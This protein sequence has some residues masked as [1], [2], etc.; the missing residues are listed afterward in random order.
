MTM[1]LRKVDNL[2]RMIRHHDSDWLTEFDI[3]GVMVREFAPRTPTERGLSVWWIHEDL[4]NLND[5]IAAIGLA[6]QRKLAPIQYLTFPEEIVSSCGLNLQQTN[7]ATCHVEAAGYHREILGLTALKT[8]TLTHEAC[9]R[10]GFQKEKLTEA[11]VLDRIVE[12]VS[13]DDSILNRVGRSS[14][15]GEQILDRLDGN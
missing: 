15:L 10:S 6:P 4:E 2:N 9:L 12:V 11:N 5:V 7:G 1:L 14:A 13:R 3:P 8:G